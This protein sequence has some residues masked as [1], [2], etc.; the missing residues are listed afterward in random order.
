MGQNLAHF[1]N[2]QMGYPFCRI[3][4]LTRCCSIVFSKI[5]KAFAEINR[6]APEPK[7]TIDSLALLM[8]K[9]GRRTG[10]MKMATFASCNLFWLGRQTHRSLDDDRMNLEIFKYCATVLVMVMS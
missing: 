3:N 2:T 7:G 1:V 4:V 6:P 5:L 9:F 8:Q 10:D